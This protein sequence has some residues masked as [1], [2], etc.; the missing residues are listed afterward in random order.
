MDY[1]HANGR[2]WLL[3]HADAN[4]A[5]HISRDSIAQ[6]NAIVRD[7]RLLN[8]SC[9]DENCMILGGTLDR[10][11]VGGKTVVAGD[12]LLAEETVVKCKVISGSPHIYHSML[13]GI[14]EV[15]DEPTIAEVHLFDGV[16]VYGTAKLIGPWELGGF[17]RIHEG[18]W[19]RPPLY[20][21]LEHA[22]I[23][24]CIDGKLLI[25]CRCRTREYWLRHGPAFGRRAGW[26][27]KQIEETFEAVMNF[28][29]VA[30]QPTYA[31]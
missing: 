9:A 24:E 27:E 31:Y 12:P 13:G 30:V 22:V 20:V 16:M 21:Q 29:Q 4:K 17:A 11:Y 10:S 23:T 3:D 28:S 6:G 19:M 18:D 2:G 14:V 25:E 26:S 15:C 7:A 5:A 8:G 1:R